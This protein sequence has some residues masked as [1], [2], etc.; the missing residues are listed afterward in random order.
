MSEHNGLAQANERRRLARFSLQLPARVSIAQ[1]RGEVRELSTRDISAYGVFLVTEH[2][3]LEGTWMRLELALP[4]ENYQQLF[5]SIGRE[6]RLKVRGVVIRRETEGMAV[7]FDR[8]YR[9]RSSESQ[10]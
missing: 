7:R 1:R 3:E 5:H 6:V 9:F 4:V 10:E 8:K 2:P